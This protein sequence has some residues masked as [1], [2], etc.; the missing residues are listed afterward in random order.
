MAVSADS[1]LRGRRLTCKS[2]KDE[3]FVSM[4]EQSNTHRILVEACKAAGFVPN[5]AVSSNDIK[6][7]EKLIASG[8]GIGLLRDGANSSEIAY[9]DVAD[10]DAQYDV[11][12]Y[13]KREAAYGNVGH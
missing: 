4:G 2:L 1:A 13:Y 12:A 5:I 3:S 6:C 9:L 7:H 10:F 11:Y 8:L